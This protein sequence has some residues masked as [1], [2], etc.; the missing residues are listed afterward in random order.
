MRCGEYGGLSANGEACGRKVGEPGKCKAHSD[1]AVD[2]MAA[3][4]VA[5]LKLFAEGSNA[6]RSAAAQVGVGVV[7]VWRWRQQD[8]EF[9]DAMTVAQTDADAV[10]VALAEDSLFKRIIDGTASA[11]ETIFFLK[12][13]APNR[14]RDMQRVQY[15]G[16]VEVSVGVITSER[17]AEVWER[18]GRIRNV[19]RLEEELVAASRKQLGSGE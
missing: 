3:S 6:I 8:P 9:N 1:E 19:E 2:D 7:T 14:W 10:R 15:T 4:K 17:A 13:R 5:F 11:A 16:E 12:N 18:M